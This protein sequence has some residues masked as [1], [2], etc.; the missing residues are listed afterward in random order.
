MRTAFKILVCCYVLIT[1]D[2]CIDADP[3]LNKAGEDE[4]K[5][6]EIENPLD[7]EDI[8][9][10]DVVYVPIYSDIYIDTAN[11]Q[12]LLSA[13][14]SIRN[15]SFTDSLYISKIDYYN[16][17]GNLARQYID[18]TIS[19]KPMETVNY[20]IEKEDA[21]GGSGANFIVEL[22][23]KNSQIK[24]LIQAIMIGKLSHQSFSFLTDGYSIKNK[25]PITAG[26]KTDN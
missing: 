23:A 5:S 7:K 22:R 9:Y 4:F 16:T 8:H 1:F 20:V 3:N 24:P 11:P 6:L 18:N 10:S 19:L 12:H 25:K 14:L 17:E 26:K 21:I 2:S 15:T 13:T